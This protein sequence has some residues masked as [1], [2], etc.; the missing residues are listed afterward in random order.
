MPLRN[1][2]DY[3]LSN[4]HQPLLHAHYVPGTVLMFQVHSQ[5]LGSQWEWKARVK[6]FT[7]QLQE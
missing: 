3:S 6:L 1:N 5:T 2:N 7:L 4:K